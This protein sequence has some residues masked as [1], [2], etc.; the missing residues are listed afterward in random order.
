MAFIEMELKE[1]PN[2]SHAT[3]LQQAWTLAHRCIESDPCW[4]LKNIHANAPGN[5]NPELERMHAVHPLHAPCQPEVG[6]S[7]VAPGNPTPLQSAHPDDAE[8]S[9]VQLG[10]GNEADEDTWMGPT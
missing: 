10:Y 4:V 8:A 6:P 1:H 2:G 9:D 3:T 5:Y 7:S